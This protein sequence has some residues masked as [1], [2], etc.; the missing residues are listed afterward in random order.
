MATQRSTEPRVNGP[1]T[2][3]GVLMSRAVARISPEARLDELAR[4]LAAVE[5]GALGVGTTEALV[6][7]VSERDLTRAYGTGD[8]PDDLRAG[9]IASPDI[10]WCEPDTSAAEAARIMVDRGI[11]HLLIGDDSGGDLQGI[12]SARDLMEA[13][14][15]P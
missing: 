4:K 15:G 11:R 5:A 9:D 1:E 7:I 3:V 14:V 2:P 12:V 8:A 13:L 10:I 6:G